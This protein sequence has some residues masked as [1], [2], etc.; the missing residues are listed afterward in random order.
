MSNTKPV[1]AT[2]TYW[3]RAR[4][5]TKLGT[6]EAKVTF[7]QG[8]MPVCAFVTPDVPGWNFSNREHAEELAVYAAIQLE[9]V[10][11]SNTIVTEVIEEN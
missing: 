6:L 11:G 9:P 3:V 1:T 10:I 7:G 2:S 8:S 4:L 5:A